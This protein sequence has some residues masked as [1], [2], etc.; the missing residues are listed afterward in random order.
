VQVDVSAEVDAVG[1]LW[2]AMVDHHRRLAG[3]DLPVRP[4]ADSWEI[5]RAD[6]ARALADG[7]GL[8]LLARE[9]GRAVGYA[10]LLLVPSGQ[11]F[12]FGELRGEVDALAVAPDVRG[13]GVGTALLERARQELWDRGCRYWSIGV[14]EANAGAAALYERVGFRPWLRE[15]AAPLDR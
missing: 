9:G 7:S 2:T 5:C 6:Y 10:F 8:L 14:L 12:D 3:T 4:P 13:A 1:P 15:L 11:M